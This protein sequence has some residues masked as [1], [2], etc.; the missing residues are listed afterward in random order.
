MAQCSEGAQPGL[1]LGRDGGAGAAGQAGRLRSWEHLYCQQG[2][3]GWEARPGM[4]SGGRHGPLWG[5]NPVIDPVHIIGHTG[6]DARLV[7][8]PAAVA[9][10]DDAIQV[11][12]AVLLTG[13]RPA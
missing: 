3:D 13:Q 6:V 10:A 8:P 9:P 4:V 12:H 11:G 1:W 2:G 7:E 5:P